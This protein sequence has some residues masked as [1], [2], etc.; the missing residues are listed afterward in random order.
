MGFEFKQ[1]REVGVFHGEPRLPV[2][3]SGIAEAGPR[4]YRVL[5]ALGWLMEL[6]IDFQEASTEN[7]FR[8]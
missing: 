4:F 6:C 7:C 5:H 1:G 8:A 3:G 2:A